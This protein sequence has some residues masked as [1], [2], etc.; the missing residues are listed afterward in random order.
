MKT[1]LRLIAV[2]GLLVPTAAHAQAQ[3]T[4]L[5]G[6]PID[7]SVYAAFDSN[8]R[9]YGQF[10]R[11]IDG[12]YALI[13]DFDRRYES[14]F[15][16]TV[17][18]ALEH[19]TQRWE[20]Q[21]G[22]LVYQRSRT[23]HRADAEAL[24]RA[25]PGVGVGN[26]GWLHSVQIVSILD[27][28]TMVVTN[29]WLVSREEVTNDYL[30]DQRGQERRDGEVNHDELQFNHQS[31]IALVQMQEDPSHGFTG[32]FRLVG[33]DTRGLESGE[34]WDGPENE[35]L[36][37]VVVRWEMSEADEQPQQ[38]RSIPDVTGQTRGGGNVQ[39][40]PVP[41]LVIAEF[42]QAMRRR[43]D[44]DGFKRLL[45]S[46]GMTVTQFVT[47]VREMRSADRDNADERIFNQLMPV[48]PEEVVEYFEGG[49]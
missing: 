12:E 2:L 32:M 8:W 31:R 44:E 22:N 19:M 39:S 24:S 47:M 41:R 37:V 29:A 15:N 42:E 14:S 5:D 1:L 38:Q 4:E 45:A 20:E 3:Q 48:I 33:F 40:G 28:R 11:E 17:S 27:E 13:P 6:T 9:Q 36:Q 46:R 34:R 10:A 18:M 7:R 43:I 16:M 35:G 30:T 25:L 23:P 21:R 49:G 26:Y